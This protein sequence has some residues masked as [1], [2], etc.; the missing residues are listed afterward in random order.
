MSLTNRLLLTLL[1][2]SL[3]FGLTIGAL[4]YRAEK[5]FDRLFHALRAQH[6]EFFQGGLTL[7]GTAVEGYVSSYSWWDDMVTFVGQP[8]PAWASL[9]VDNIV[10]IPNGGEA[11][12]ILTPELQVIHSIDADSRRP[13]PPFRDPT[14]LRRLVTDNYSFSFFTELNGQLW[15]VYGAAIQDPQFWRHET[16]VVGYL[17]L[18]KRW[19]ETWRARLSDLVQSRL[20][21]RLSGAPVTSS[22]EE[23]RYSFAHPMLGLGGELVATIVGRFDGSNLDYVVNK[24]RQ[25]FVVAIVVFFVAVTSLA[26]FLILSMLRPLGR[27]TRSLES[28]NPVHL[29]DL[30]G[31]KNEFGEIAR[32]L[33]SQFRQGRM[34]R[35][36]ISRR[37]AEPSSEAARQE[38]ESNTALRLQ[39]ASDL[40]DGPLQ[41]LYAAGLKISG[42]EARLGSGEPPSAS[43]LEDLRGLLAGCTSDLRNLLLDLEPQDLQD[44]DLENAL[45]RLERYML[46]VSR[47][48]ARLH[49]EDG[50]LDGIDRSYQRQA[51][52]MARELVSNASRHARP[53]RTSLS[54]TRQSGFLVIHWENDGFT[55]VDPLIPGNG[56]RNI[57]I[58]VQQL[59]GTWSYRIVRNSLWQVHIE[60]PF[61]TLINSSPIDIALTPSLPA[62]PKRR[63]S[64]APFP[65]EKV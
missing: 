12:W 20:T 55:P 62:S 38:R 64:S 16:P 11:L 19:D 17:L 44:E 14:E 56:L 39:L 4:W 57:G 28:R 18:G 5:S 26:T 52:Y 61:S 25:R 40:H 24:T 51:Y 30:I 41:S 27:L 22:E 45:Q 46:S 65:E 21:V 58:R 47:K 23:S 43:A 7:Q 29:L 48:E 36:E 59:D 53:N 10:G 15:Q 13:P 42:L 6:V 60:L 35:D 63:S 50:V 2:T 32:L 8:D 1:V 54:F 34:L 9:N 49:I 31:A 3:A 37:F 33:S